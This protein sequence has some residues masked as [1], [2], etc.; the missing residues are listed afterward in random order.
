MTKL[1]R[2]GLWL[3]YLFRDPWDIEANQ[4]MREELAR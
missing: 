2:L 1:R 3:R 4:K